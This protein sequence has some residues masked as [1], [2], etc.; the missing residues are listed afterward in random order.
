MNLHNWF[1]H[2]EVLWLLVLLI[3]MS[4]WYFRKNKDLRASLT[5]SVSEPFKKLGTNFWYK[6]RHILFVIRSLTL[7]LLIIAAARPQKTTRFGNEKTEGIDIVLALDISSS[8]L[9]LDFKPN[10]LEVAKKVATNFIKE[11]PNDR[12]GIVAFAAESFTVCPLT[13]DH[14]TAINLLNRLQTG[15]IEDGTAIGLGLANA[16]A[17]LHKS[18]AKSKVI[19]LLTDGVN[20]TG[21]I[22]PLDAA[23]M[24]KNYGIRVYTIGIGSMGTAPYPVQTPLGIQY[25]NQKVEID[26]DILKQIAQKTGG[27]YFRATDEQKL[28]EIYKEIDKMEK[29]IFEK[30]E[31]FKTELFFEPFL[32]AAFVLLVSEIILRL[33]VYR[34]IP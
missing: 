26:E 4:I 8:M 15:M 13:T 24:A 18:K 12:I 25:I 6:I 29:T 3:P 32:I 7:I 27:K 23:E 10:R 1:Q 16:V 2:P 14:T 33:T 9:A 34:T 31:H 20:N 28:I 17:R 21:N 11:R 22:S 5:I 30:Q 19:I